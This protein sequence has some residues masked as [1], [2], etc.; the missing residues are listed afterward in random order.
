MSY[1]PESAIMRL[2]ESMGV[3]VLHVETLSASGLLNAGVK[4]STYYATR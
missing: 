3:R 1:I 2:F 4:S